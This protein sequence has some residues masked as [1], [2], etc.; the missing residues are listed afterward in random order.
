[1]EFYCVRRMAGSSWKEAKNIISGRGAFNWGGYQ[2]NWT[3]VG[4]IYSI[5]LYAR[6]RTEGEIIV[7]GY[8]ATMTG[9]YH[10]A[11]PRAHFTDEVEW[12]RST[13]E[14]GGAVPFTHFGF[15]AGIEGD[16]ELYA[17]GWPGIANWVRGGRWTL[18][19]KAFTFSVGM[20]AVAGGSDNRSVWAVGRA[21]E[22]DFGNWGSESHG[23]LYH[24]EWPE[25]RWQRMRL[26]GI[27]FEEAQ[28]LLG[29]HAVDRSHLFIV[30]ENGLFIRGVR[31]RNRSWV[32]QRVLMPSLESLYR[33]LVNEF[34]LWVIGAKVTILNSVDHGQHW[35]ALDVAGVDS[36][37]LGIRFYGETG[38][39]VGNNVV[40]KCS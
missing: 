15:L 7:N 30:G 4:P 2:Y 14:P 27:E 20:V 36:A 35:T 9:M 13:P 18:Q 12:Q 28:N 23:A 32:W 1:M 19:M 6:E 10:A 16:N 40:L 29:L 3:D 39:I 21:G 8:I 31:D 17:C 11:A 38:W 25:N 34:G 33:V 5:L 24:L 37:L 26:S 22:D